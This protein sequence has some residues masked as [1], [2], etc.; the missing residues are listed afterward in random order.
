MT[1]AVGD[2]APSFTLRSQHGE[3]IALAD[4]AGAKSVVLL[5]YPFA[6]SSVCTGELDAIRDRLAEL[7]GDAS[8]VLAV[9]CDPVYALRVFA[10]R[11]GLRFPL[12]SDF[13]PH[14]ATATSYGVF[15]HRLGAANRSTFI[16]D[17]AGVVRWL[18]H[19]ELGQARDIDDYLGVLADL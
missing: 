15:N 4:Y 16:I 19:N 2:V 12:L 14:G 3:S 10:D 9:S 17:R 13:W 18:V 7:Q 6:F 11:D 5:F 8:E 1:V